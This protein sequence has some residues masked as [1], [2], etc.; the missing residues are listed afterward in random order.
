MPARVPTPERRDGDTDKSFA[1]LADYARMGAGR[2]LR[3]LHESYQ[4]RGQKG[5]GPGTDAPPTKRWATLSGWAHS[6]DWQARVQDYDEARR[7]IADEE[8][9]REMLEGLAL[10]SHRVRALKLLAAALLAD[11]A[12]AASAKDA[13]EGAGGGRSPLAGLDLTLG[14]PQRL[15]QLRGLLDDL[16]KETGGR[17]KTVDLKSD[18]KAISGVVF[19]APGNGQTIASDRENTEGHAD[20]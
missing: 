9:E 4:A 15:A 10:P 17:T 12:D 3:A 5:D 20:E 16:A 1:A 6:N 2:S 13:E 14:S 18:G 19:S 7:A 11:D 8:A